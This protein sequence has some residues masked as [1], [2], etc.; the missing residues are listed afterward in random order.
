M[1]SHTKFSLM[2]L[3]IL[4]LS[5]LSAQALIQ[6]QTQQLTPSPAELSFCNDDSA[7]A[8]NQFT[9]RMVSPVVGP[10]QLPHA[11]ITYKP[12]DPPVV[13]KKCTASVSYPSEYATCSNSG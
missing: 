5:P 9:C 11:I 2:C 12:C 10:V 4:G 3:L 6:Q 7:A 13:G 8:K 1:T